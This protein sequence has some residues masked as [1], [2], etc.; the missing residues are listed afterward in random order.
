MDDANRPSS[1]EGAG[2]WFAGGEGETH[3][4]AAWSYMPSNEDGRAV[5]V[6]SPFGYAYS[7]SFRLWR[8]VSERLAGHGIRVLRIDPAGS[9][10]SGGKGDDVS[11]LEPIRSAVSAGVDLLRRHGSSSIAIIGCELTGSLA[12][13]EGERLGVEL[14][15]AVS[16]VVSGKRYARRQRILSE[17]SPD[18]SGDISV[19]G[20]YMSSSLLRELTDLDLGGV[21]TPT[22]ATC[23]VERS[24]DGDA[25]DLSAKWSRDSSRHSFVATSELTEVLDRQAEEATFAKDLISAVADPILSGLPRRTANGDLALIDKLPTSTIHSH[26]GQPVRETFVVLGPRAWRGVLT[27]S[28]RRDCARSETIVVFLNSGSDPH[29]GPGRA[30]V[31][32]A[33]DMAALGFAVLRV[34][35]RGWGDSPDGEKAP[36]RPC[37]LQAFDDTEELVAHLRSEGWR[38]VVL[39]GLC[40]GAWVS[41]DVAR[42]VSVDGVL[43]INPPMY[44]HR[45][46]PIIPVMALA[47]ESRKDEIAMIKKRARNGDWDREDEAGIR[48]PAGQ[49]LDDLAASNTHISLIFSEGDDGL[50]YLR[51][52][53]GR[54]LKCVTSSADIHLFEIADI[55]HAM[56]RTWYRKAMRDRLIDSLMRIQTG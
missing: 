30:W 46:A 9:G 26:D 55:D 12:I 11:S 21:P 13:L 4:L 44:W 27:T 54:R 56:H 17:H 20:M 15:V 29:A 2:H 45:G 28:D 50:E 25:S 42:R 48:P 23:L 47:H 40:S 24:E 31:E 19:A 5:L 8:T 7:S 3:P 34:D 22:I 32:Y 43:A 41:L 35:L 18:G 51:D 49:W 37:D 38:K 14:V 36:G 53:L 1:R 16:P 6:V 10:D 33:R 39:A 52:R